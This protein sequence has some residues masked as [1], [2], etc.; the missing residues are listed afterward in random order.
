MEA[1]SLKTLHSSAL[2][3]PAL[4]QDNTATATTAWD[5]GSG[6]G[7]RSAALGRFF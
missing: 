2:L 6:E 7:S 3:A 5:P 4:L 1:E